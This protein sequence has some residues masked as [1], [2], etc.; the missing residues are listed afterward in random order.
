MKKLSISLLALL[1]F[2]I[3]SFAQIT[4]KEVDNVVNRTLTAFNVPGIAIAIVKDG[5]VVLTKGYGVK[6]I[7]T[8]EKVDA[9][10]LFGIASNSKA[11]TSAAL[12][13]LVDEGKLK[14]DDKVITY[15]PNFKMY[16][17]YVTNEF[18]IRDLLTHRSGLGLGAG[19]LMIWP[20]GSNFTAQDITQNLQYLKP[21]SAFRTQY[22]YDNLLYI[23]AGE[24]VHKV[25]GMSW[26]DFIESRIMK[27]LEMNN[28]AAS[29]VRLKDT[30][31]VIAPHV[32]ING[33][34]KVISRYKNQLF[35]A[36]AGIYSSVNDLSKWAIMQLNNGKYSSE[37]KQLFSEK[38]HTE[39][40]TPQTIIP[41]KT[42]PPYNTHFS[43]YGLGWFLSDVK[44]YKQATHTGGLEGIVTQT[45][46]IPE[47]NLGIIV[48][49]NQQS[50][51]AFNAITNTIKDSYLGIKSE[52]YVTIYSN[53]VKATEESA[54]KI[55]DEVW[56]LVAKNKKDNIKID[57]NNY[58][59]T[60]KDNWF[61]QIVISEKKGKLYFASKRSPQLSGELFLHKD[62]NL[63][64]KWNNAYFHADA[65]LFF[66]FDA[67]GKA[68]AIK[69]KPISELTDFSYDFQDLDFKREM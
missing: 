13:M 19:D 40:W 26:C 32:P 42:K 49:T 33:K 56:A 7:L 67:N 24:V 45:T 4:E 9:N 47:L 27:P 35:D 30:S 62:K 28:S 68:I 51:A 63:V 20:D 25:S 69:M 39:M 58:V 10:S 17:D 2:S 31:N 52:D 37:N 3:H 50:G 46:L 57:F 65:H 54:D 60:Y 12:A 22:D 61:G 23:V 59:G 21:V 11:F 16:N 48:L 44:G 15:L 36:A 8:N 18:T 5:K 14:W 41:A 29:F 66:E 38:E 1:A 6:S 64:A 43:S 34:L 53:R 55:T